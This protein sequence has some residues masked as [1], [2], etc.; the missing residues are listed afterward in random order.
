MQE[1]LGH[2]QIETTLIYLRLL[3][4]GVTS[5]LDRL[6]PMVPASQAPNMAARR[7]DAAPSHQSP[8]P[9]DTASPSLFPEPLTTDGLTLPFAPEPSGSCEAV[10][11]FYQVLRTRLVGGFLALKRVIRSPA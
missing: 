1:R 6:D 9:N 3:H 7:S 4:P 10:R 8:I 11:A 2:K 5:P